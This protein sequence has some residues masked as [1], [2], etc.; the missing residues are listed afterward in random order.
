MAFIHPSPI[1]S[2]YVL[3]FSGQ[4]SLIFDISSSDTSNAE[5]NDNDE[6][7][8]Y[9]PPIPFKPIVHLSPVET[10][11]GEEDE[12]ILFREHAKLYRFDSPTNEMKERGIGEMKILQHKTTN[13]CRVLMRRDQVFKVCANH[14]ITPEMELKEHQGKEN[15]YIWSAVDYADREA[16]HEI[17]CVKFKTSDQAKRFFQQF[18]DAKQ[19]NA[20]IQQ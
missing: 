4:D 15:A 19:T 7:D 9:E 10:K 2:I 12:N 11:T 5:N 13:L 6:E 8:T 20:N 17:L 3:V 1:N 18:N 16:K 14:K